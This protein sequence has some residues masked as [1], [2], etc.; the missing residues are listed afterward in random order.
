MEPDVVSTH[1]ID[2]CIME[3]GCH[4]LEYLNFKVLVE[5]TLK[6]WFPIFKILSTFIFL[7]REC[8]TGGN[9]GCYSKLNKV[10]MCVSSIPMH[11]VFYECKSFQ[12]VFKSH[13]GSSGNFS[14]F[15]RIC[16]LFRSLIFLLESSIIFFMCFKYFVSTPP[17][18]MHPFFVYYIVMHPS[19]VY[20]II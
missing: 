5:R 2:I 19:F 4:T 18:T 3:D 16:S 9:N 1:H 7:D 6:Q 13:I 10:V 8:S 12:N 15:S 14:T 11:L 17:W 20:Y